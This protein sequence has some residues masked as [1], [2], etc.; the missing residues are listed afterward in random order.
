M[1]NPLGGPLGASPSGIPW[2]IPLGICRG[3]SLPGG[4][5]LGESPWGIPL[6]ESVLTEDIH[7]HAFLPPGSALYSL[8]VSIIGV[9][10]P[11]E[12][13]RLHT[14]GLGINPIDWVPRP[15]ES[16][17]ILEFDSDNSQFGF[18]MILVRPVKLIYSPWD[19]RW[20][21]FRS[22]AA[23]APGASSPGLPAM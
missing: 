18:S 11:F 23:L 3:I 12:V 13:P 17:P 9:P 14:L 1:E 7:H 19:R 21:A 8:F 16:N 4:S 20:I 22:L 2:G 6:G 10:V 5:T 15:P